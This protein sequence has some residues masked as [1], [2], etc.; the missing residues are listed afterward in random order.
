M[1]HRRSLILAIAA[2]LGAACSHHS[3]ATSE[4]AAAT[5][6]LPL[7][8]HLLVISVDGL[9]PDALDGASPSRLPCFARLLSGASTLDA[10]TDPD[11]TVTLPNHTGMMTGRFV[12]GADGH[13]WRQNDVPPADQ[14]LRNDVASIFNVAA[15][16]GYRCALFAAKPKFVLYPRSWNGQDTASAAGPIHEFAIHTEAEQVVAA[17]VDFW[18]KNPS[19]ARSLVFAHLREPDAAGHSQGWDLDPASPYSASV[20]RVDASLAALFV[21][22]DARPE[23]SSR[24]AIVLTTDHG[25]G[26]PL[27]N[28]HG[29]SRI[30]VNFTIPFLVWTGDGR[31]SG[32]LYLSNQD[33]RAQPGA[34]DPRPGDPGLPP[35]R[36]ADAANL[37]LALLGLPAVPG[38]IV[39]VRQDLRIA[40]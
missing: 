36:N 32:D 40:Q 15:E 14:R 11:W 9:R 2:L 7:Y 30:A 17:V 20:A 39:N 37:A 13:H 22:L 29:E 5:A 35:I 1:I 16:A 26:A 33:S 10:R 23:R 3:G 31:A 8:D 24:T 34:L 25:G 38:S 4:P 18:E 27:K 6:S 19:P 12:E 28:H 21:W